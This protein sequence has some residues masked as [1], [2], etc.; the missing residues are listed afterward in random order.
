MEDEDDPGAEEYPVAM[1]QLYSDPDART[2]E[3][4]YET[5][6]VCK[7]MGVHRM[8]V[9]D[10]KSICALVAMIPY[11]LTQD[12]LQQP[13]LC[14]KF[15]NCYYVGEKLALDNGLPTSDDLEDDDD[16]DV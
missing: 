10:V 13:E 11:P 12:E 2:L 15:P 1:I 6:V 5:L 7:Y 16:V 4:S 3:V 8:C 9:I 14:S